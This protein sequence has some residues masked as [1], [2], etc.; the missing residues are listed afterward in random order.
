MQMG[1]QSWAY[2]VQVFAS[3]YLIKGNFVETIKVKKMV[4]DWSRL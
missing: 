1:F 3:D 2:M 4:N